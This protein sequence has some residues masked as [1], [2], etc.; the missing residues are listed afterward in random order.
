MAVG[1]I[2]SPRM[3]SSKSQF[4]FRQMALQPDGRIVIATAHSLTLLKADGSVD[5]TFGDDG[6][7]VP[8]GWI[9]AIAV[10]GNGKIVMSISAGYN[11]R[12]MRLNSDGSPDLSFGY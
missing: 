9:D 7:M 2:R 4:D 12:L 1:T 5:N 3:D 6:V 10:Q 8:R 11:S